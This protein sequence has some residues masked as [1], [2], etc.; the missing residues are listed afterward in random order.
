MHALA[1]AA[2][3]AGGVDRVSTTN[4]RAYQAGLSAGLGVEAALLADDGYR[5]DESILDRYLEIIGFDGRPTD[6]D[7][8]SRAFGAG[9]ALIEQELMIKL[10]PGPFLYASAVEAALRLA[11]THDVG[12]EA[13][14]RLDVYGTAFLE[15][16]PSRRPPP[17][18]SLT[19][20]IASAIVRG[21]MRWD[22]FA[23]TPNDGAV[24]ADLR[25]RVHIHRAGKAQAPGD[26]PWAARVVLSTRSGAEHAIV[27]DAPPG[28]AKAGLEWNAVEDK[29]HALIGLGGASPS[30]ILQKVHG[31]D[32]VDNV[33]PLVAELR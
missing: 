22:H 27:V 16:G 10:R 29:V 25:E 20:C 9:S 6:R 12:A 19:Y 33:L 30:A 8:P 26:W 24:V 13:I 3:T 7:V 14:D 28:S 23:Q 17:A 2:T 31:L 32:K 15:E 18:G 21:G 11:D 1:F 4:A 5:A